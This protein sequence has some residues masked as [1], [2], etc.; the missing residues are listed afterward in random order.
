MIKNGGFGKP[1][2][3][4]ILVIVSGFEPLAFRLGVAKETAYNQERVGIFRVACHIFSQTLARLM[5]ILTYNSACYNVFIT[6]LLRDIEGKL[7]WRKISL[8]LVP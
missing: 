8:L 3:P 5:R 7:K 6:R 1:R 4:R 2:N